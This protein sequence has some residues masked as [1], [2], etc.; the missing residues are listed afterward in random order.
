MSSFPDALKERIPQQESGSPSP[1]GGFAA[2]LS[3]GLPVFLG[4]A[5]VGAAFGVLASRLG[6]SV[7]EAAACSATALAGAG[8]FIALSL[9]GGGATVPA[10]L[11]ATAVVNLRYVLFSATLAPHLK[12]VSRPARSWLAFTLTDETFAV[13][14]TG[15]RKGMA[16]PAS[17]AGVGFIAWCG[18]VL[19]TIA[20][21]SGAGLISDPRA[22][23][24]DFA[25]AAMFSALFVALAENRSHVV[26][27]VAA[28]ALVLALHW[29]SSMGV[30]I[31]PS[32]FI[33]IAAI[34]AAT[35]ATVASNGR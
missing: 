19:G 1:A 2:G 31:E 17:M 3:A 30:R 11:I 34:S 13:N 24:V 21:A 28:G 8:Q 15:I 12:G 22:W 14:I 4:Y 35:I 16:T 9:L 25:M 18:W 23:G 7:W 33:V 27:G 29:A 26:T 6:F 10:T 20:G 5:P 32:W